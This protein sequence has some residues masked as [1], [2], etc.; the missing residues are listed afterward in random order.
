MGERNL[1]AETKRSMERA[2]MPVSLAASRFPTNSGEAAVSIPPA[3]A[4]V[5]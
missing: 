2:E 5:S 4:D 1:P 3:T